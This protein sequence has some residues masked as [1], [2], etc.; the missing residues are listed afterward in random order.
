MDRRAG[1]ARR[2]C[3]PVEHDG[4]RRGHR[5]GNALPESGA[6]ATAPM[7]YGTALIR[8]GTYTDDAAGEVFGTRRLSA[9]ACGLIF[10]RL[11]YTVHSGEL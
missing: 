10:R 11:H 5:C 1:I 4:A 3:R 6:S 9:S 8:L 7:T 2:R